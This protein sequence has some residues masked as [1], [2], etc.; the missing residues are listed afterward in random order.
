VD[1]RLLVLLARNRDQLAMKRPGDLIEPSRDTA[2]YLDAAFIIRPT[3]PIG[4][5]PHVD[6]GKP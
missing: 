4:V 5:V 3:D 2:D 1:K 6:P